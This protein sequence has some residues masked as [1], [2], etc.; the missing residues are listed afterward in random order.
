MKLIAAAALLS[1]LLCSRCFSTFASNGMDCKFEMKGALY[2]LS[3]LMNEEAIKVKGGDLDWTTKIEETYEYTFSV[4][5]NLKAS[6]VDKT[7]TDEGEGSAAV[8]Q[9]G[10]TTNAVKS[11]H[12]AG[13]VSAGSKFQLTDN[14][15]PAHGVK[16]NYTDGSVCKHGHDFN[17]CGGDT[18]NPCPDR[19]TTLYFVCKDEATNAEQAAEIN[20]KG[21]IEHCTYSV[22]VR[23]MHACPQQCGLSWNEDQ[24]RLAL[25]AGHGLCGWD[26]T[27]SAAKCFC[28]NGWSGKDCSTKGNATSSGGVKGLLILLL[29]ISIGLVA[30]VVFMAKQVRAYRNDATNYMQIRGQELSEQMSTI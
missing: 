29:L 15:N 5:R 2:D 26:Q 28:D 7:C 22:E 25:C 21:Q 14:S 27:N 20:E 11:C 6:E 13:K 12:N 3:D 16:L 23:T 17:E 24:N 9:V 19:Q 18:G 10:P 30:V 8:F 4:C 1:A